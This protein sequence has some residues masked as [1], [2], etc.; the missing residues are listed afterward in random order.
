MMKNLRYSSVM[1]GSFNLDDRAD[2][3]V[4]SMFR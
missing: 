3:I 1:V 4:D 2:L